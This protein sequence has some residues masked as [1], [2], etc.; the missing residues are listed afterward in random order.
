MIRG[1][2]ERGTGH[3]M[4]QPYPHELLFR[5]RIWQTAL[6]TLSAIPFALGTETVPVLTK[7]AAISNALEGVVAT[8]P[9]KVSYF[10]LLEANILVPADAARKIQ[11]SQVNF[12]DCCI[13]QGPFR[14]IAG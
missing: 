11:R 9:E 13:R 8:G 4:P 10:L 6:P 12:V 5:S 7:M 3:R 2:A 1:P 14:G